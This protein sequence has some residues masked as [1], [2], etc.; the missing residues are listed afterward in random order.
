[1]SETGY[2]L[3]DFKAKKGIKAALL[4]FS[5][6]LFFVLAA[7]FALQLTQSDDREA[8]RP[9]TV[10]T[11][12]SQTSDA[13]ASHDSEL[14]CLPGHHC[15]HHICLELPA[16]MSVAPVAPRPTWTLLANDVP[17]SAPYLERVPRPPSA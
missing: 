3:N 15:A 12:H 9:G 17:P 16:S 14:P 11:P 6:R 2:R 13:H 8:A 4:S 10:T 5:P 1:M 7:I